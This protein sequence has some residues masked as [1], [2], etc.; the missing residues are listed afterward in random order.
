[1]PGDLDGQVTELLQRLTSDLEIWGV[2]AGRFRVDLFCGLFMDGSNE[3]FNL[4]TS[5]LKALGDRGIELA[6]DIYAPPSE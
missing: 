4:S 1:M 5:A 2:L 3:G 6:L